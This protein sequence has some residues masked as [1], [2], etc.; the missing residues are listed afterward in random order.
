MATAFILKLR[1]HT[2]QN[3]TV[4]ETDSECLKGLFM[5]GLMSTVADMLRYDYQM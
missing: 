4:D 1:L 5:K 2:C 3:K